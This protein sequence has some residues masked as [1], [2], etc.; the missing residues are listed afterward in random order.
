[1]MGLSRLVFSFPLITDFKDVFGSWNT[2]EIFRGVAL[3]LP[4]CLRRYHA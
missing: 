3:S 4:N 2:L 1:M